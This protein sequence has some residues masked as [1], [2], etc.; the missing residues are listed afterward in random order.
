[1]RYFVSRNL[2]STALPIFVFFIGLANDVQAETRCELILTL[3]Q[4]YANAEILTIVS[5]PP[6]SS[7]IDNARNNIFELNAYIYGKERLLNM[8]AV[9]LGH[10]GWLNAYQ[11]SWIKYVQT[12]D[13][14]GA[15]SAKLLL[16]SE[17]YRHDQ[18]DLDVLKD[19]LGC[20]GNIITST[21]RKVSRLSLNAINGAFGLN[22]SAFNQRIS[23]TAAMLLL[24]T[25]L[26]FGASLFWVAQRFERYRKDCSRRYQ[27]DVVVKIE[28]GFG[29]LMVKTV[30]I[31]RNGICLQS[32]QKFA[33]G[34]KVCILLEN[35]W[36]RSKV[37]WVAGSKV[38]LKFAFR[39]RAI[40]QFATNKQ[41]IERTIQQRDSFSK[42]RLS[43]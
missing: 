22:T 10:P 24:I 18:Q 27:C 5:P 3:E 9:L 35:R 28:G 4:I 41:E 25:A 6:S 43:P 31:S 38:G 21:L 16:T 11:I 8:S 37:V 19:N 14:G 34:D 13:I 7:Q 2:C 1:M 36:R 17:R 30:N 23:S 29:L 26:A 12:Y 33:R 20:D 42:P 40:P 39:M 15:R 32:E